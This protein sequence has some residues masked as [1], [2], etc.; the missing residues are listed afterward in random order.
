MLVCILPRRWRLRTAKRKGRVKAGICEAYRM[1]IRPDA[2]AFRVD[3]MYY[4]IM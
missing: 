4:G 3:G 2:G 1:G